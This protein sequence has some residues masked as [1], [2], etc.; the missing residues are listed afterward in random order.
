[1][2]SQPAASRRTLLRGA[3][4]AG[5]AGAG[6]TACGDGGG[7]GGTGGGEAP[8]APVDLGAADEVPVGGARLYRE[9][10]LLVSRPAE[11]EYKAFSA[12]CTHQR[13][14]LSAVEGTGADC[15]CHGSRFDA[16]TGKAL[17]G[18]ATKALPAVPVSVRDGRL[19]AGGDA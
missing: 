15:A 19:V 1:M 18:P 14:V 6:L 12:V 13:C 7:G 5:A 4:L 10:R 17:R 11:D 16:E 9:Q 8:S 2:T 3:A